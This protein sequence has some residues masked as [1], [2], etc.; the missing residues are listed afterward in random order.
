MESKLSSKP[1]LKAWELLHRDKLL[2]Q[3]ACKV[4]FRLLKSST[5]LTIYS[6]SLKL[7]I[8]HSFIVVPFTVKSW[9]LL[10]QGMCAKSTSIYI[11][12]CIYMKYTVNYM[13]MWSSECNVLCECMLAKACI[14]ECTLEC[15]SVHNVQWYVVAWRGM[16]KYSKQWSVKI[17]QCWWWCMIH[18]WWYMS[19][20]DMMMHTLLDTCY[21]M[22]RWCSTILCHG[23][24]L[25][26]SIS[27]VELLVQ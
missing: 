18:T 7:E 16:F 3:S 14:V 26:F 2:E 9:D 25:V 27:K 13:I 23:A 10:W 6:P 12:C 22:M 1:S 8:I 20:L 4:K 17:L 19:W 11:H 24:C 15:T 5:A 21:D